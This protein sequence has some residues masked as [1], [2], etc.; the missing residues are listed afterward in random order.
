MQTRTWSWGTLDHSFCLP[1]FHQQK[2]ATRTR[3]MDNSSFWQTQMEGTFNSQ[4]QQSFCLAWTQQMDGP[5]K[6]GDAITDNWSHPQCPIVNMPPSRTL[7]AW[8]TLHPPP[9]C[10][11]LSPETKKKFTFCNCNHM[12]VHCRICACSSQLLAPLLFAFFLMV[13][14]I[15]CKSSHQWLSLHM[16]FEPHQWIQRTLVLAILVISTSFFCKQCEAHL[17]SSTHFPNNVAS[18]FWESWSHSLSSMPPTQITFHFAFCLDAHPFPPWLESFLYSSVLTSFTFS[19]FLLLTCHVHLPLCDHSALSSSLF[20]P[21]D[22]SQDIQFIHSRSVIMLV[23]NW[24]KRTNSTRLHWQHCVCNGWHACTSI[25]V[26][27]WAISCSFCVCF[28]SLQTNRMHSPLKKAGTGVSG[29]C[30]QT[31]A[32][33]CQH[34]PFG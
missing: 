18:S 4:H 26:N 25:C 27:C 17:L 30:V 22:L 9:H 34:A 32:I 10:L 3:T 8:R 12:H 15:M 28:L 24:W 6:S 7:P 29:L 33:T 1:S 14:A 19:N 11:A 2:S 31:L 16:I 20:F 5:Q 13:V 21:C 23:T